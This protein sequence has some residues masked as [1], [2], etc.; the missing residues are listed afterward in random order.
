MVPTQFQPIGT[1]AGT[2]RQFTTMLGPEVRVFAN[3]RFNVNIRALIGAANIDTLILP[4]PEPIQQPPDLLGNPQPPI[5]EFRSGDEKPISSAL[6]GSLDYR[7]SDRL[8]YRI[9][10][11]LV[12][13]DLGGVTN[14]KSLRL[15]TGIVFRFG[16]L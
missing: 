14:R 4:L 8:Y 12:V 15:S 11:E 7:I 9:Q 10:P 3:D 1:K 5:T 2:Y 16:R 13:V 6:G